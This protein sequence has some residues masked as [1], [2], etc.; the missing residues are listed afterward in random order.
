MTINKAIIFTLGAAAGSLVTW[1]IVEKKYKR[2]AD[3]EIESVIERFKERERSSF[4]MDADGIELRYDNEPVV[5]ITGE[6]IQC[7][8]VE[9]EEKIPF[10]E[11]VEMENEKLIKDLG[12]DVEDDTIVKTELVKEYIKPYVISPEEFGDFSNKTR[13]L[14]YYADFV[15]ADEDDYMIS[16]PEGLIGDALNHFGEYED[17]AVHVRDEN[18]EC[19]YEILKSEK[20]FSEINKGDN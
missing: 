9:I 19:D 13:S 20:T 18:I 10:T 4:K 17:D 16:D 7:A 11:L 12:Y 8:D 2:I 1:K 6:T 5:K 14:T 15:L 3:E